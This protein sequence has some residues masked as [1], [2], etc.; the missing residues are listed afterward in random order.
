MAYIDTSIL[1]AY[2][3]PEPLSEVAEQA[4]REAAFPAISMLSEVEFCSALAIKLRRGKMR[5][6]SG[7]R[8]L[9]Q[10]LLHVEEQ[11]YAILPI[12]AR[13][14]T[15]SVEWIGQFSTAIRTL[16]ALHLAIAHLNEQPLVTADHVLARSAEHFG[17]EHTLLQ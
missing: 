12:E 3:C 17:V 15:L 6:N 9:S 11:R 10:F 16:D 4:V 8:V 14:Y 7:E 5:P 1:V 2:Y 13:H